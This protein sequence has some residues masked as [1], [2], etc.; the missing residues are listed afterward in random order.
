MKEITEPYLLIQSIVNTQ[1]DLIVLIEDEKPILL[2]SAFLKFFKVNSFEQYTQDFGLFIKNFV[3]HPSYFHADKVTPNTTWIESLLALE[4]KD[5]IVSMINQ[6]GEPRAFRVTVDVSHPHYAILSFEDISADLIKC[7]MIENNVSIDKSSGAYNKNYFLHTAES[8]YDG[9]IFNEKRIGLSML[10][11]EED[12]D[13][14]KLRDIVVN[15]KKVIRNNDMLIKYSSSI[16]L[17]AYLVDSL[18]NAQLFTK[19][20]NSVLSKESTCKVLFSLV[21]EKEKIPQAL[22]RIENGLDNLEI[23]E[24]KSI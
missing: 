13:S 21:K 1:K 2:N 22:H 3:P 5:R 24:L 6:A 12:C 10:S 4:E 23:G 7:I 16:L 18:E 9:A 8:F 19:K 14:E 15:I 11:I 17:M 20:L